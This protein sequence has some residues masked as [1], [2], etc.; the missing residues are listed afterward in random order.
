MDLVQLEVFALIPEGWG[1][2]QSCEALI[3]QAGLGKAPS[4]RGLED[5]PPEI[6]EEFQ[7]LSAF[8]LDLSSRFGERLRIRIYD[9]YSLQGILKALRYSARR[10]PTFIVGGRHKVTGWELEKVKQAIEQSGK[11]PASSKG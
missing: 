3:A 6:V 8:L 9:P 7:R 10:Y 5:A 4:D 1:F 11:L 2:C